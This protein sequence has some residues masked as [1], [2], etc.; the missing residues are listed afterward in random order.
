MIIRIGQGFDVHKLVPGRKL[1]IGG[2][3][4]PFENGFEAHSDGDV[5]VHAL[6]DAMLG[7]SGF[8]DI[9]TFFPDNSKKWENA[10]SIHDILPVVHDK[11][12]S[13]GWNINNIDSTLILEK[14]KMAPFIDEI[15]TNL[16]SEL[17]IE[18]NLIALKAK[19]TEKCF[20]NPP[21]EAVI[22][23]VNILLIKQ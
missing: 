6:C 23:L 10:N 21:N 17:A 19:R 9:G 7:A 3:L 5:L 8:K 20:L 11:I 14:P 22:A 1:I 15:I 16:S 12:K 13:K 4:I 18:K 2:L